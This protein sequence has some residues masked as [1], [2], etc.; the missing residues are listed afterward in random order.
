MLGL[1][2]VSPQDHFL[3]DR[4]DPTVNIDDSLTDP[5]TLTF[6]VTQGSV[7]GPLLFTM[8]TTPLSNV[9]DSSHQ[10][11]HHLYA[12]DT[13]LYIGLTHDNAHTNLTLLQETLNHVRSWMY[14]NKLKLNPGKT[15]FMLI[16]TPKKRASLAS[17]FPIDLLGSMVTPC[18]KVRNLRVIFD[19]D[20]SFTQHVSNVIKSCYYHMRDLSRIRRH[21]SRS[22]ATSLANALVG[23]RLDYCNSLFSSI[24]AKELTSGSSKHTLPYCDTYTTFL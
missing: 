10:L 8:Y 1:Y 12:D 7:L 15:E 6:G 16:G 5:A 3:P 9:I 11:S 21:L 23:S 17:L 4:T 14:T 18:E 20:F 13:Q 2:P 19:A 24:T 22:V